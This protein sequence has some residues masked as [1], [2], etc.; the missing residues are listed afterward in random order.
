MRIA[1]LALQVTREGQASYAHV[2]E[3]IAGLR[4]RGV[5][6][7]LHEPGYARSA[8]EPG[9]LRRAVAFYRVQSKLISKLAS[10]DLLYVRGHF[11]AIWAGW[12]AR[13]LKVPVI[14]EINGPYEDLFIAWPWTRRFKRLFIGMMRWQYRAADVLVTVTNELR[15]WV[16][17]EVGE[18][19]RIEVIPNGAN[20]DLF[21]PEAQLGYNLNKPYAVFFGALALW[22]GI[23]TLLKVME[24]PDWPREVALVIAGDGAER[25]K[26]E[27]A[28]RSNPKVIFLGKVPYRELPGV[29]AN[30]LAGF[31]VKN[32]LGKRS[33]TGL[34]PLKVYETLACGVPVIVTD[35]PGQAE[36]ARMGCGIVVPEGDLGALARA[37]FELMDPGRQR[38]MGQKGRKLVEKLHSWEIRAEATYLLIQNTCLRQKR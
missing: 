13:R 16:S 29:I 36:L 26:V 34:S 4:R 28:A 2:H 35:F 6:V 24:H 22:Q 14:Q 37:V 9:I 8:A 23:D 5:E 27:A 20:I 3:I 1:Y 15:D 32:N 19:A 30:S 33:S 25:L 7:D 17:R 38:T 31:S 18:G 12:A 10:Y 21:H 11:A